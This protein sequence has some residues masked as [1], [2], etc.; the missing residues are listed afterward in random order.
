[1][2]TEIV[3]STS[4]VFRVVETKTAQVGELMNQ[5]SEASQEQKSGIEQINQEVSSMTQITE[6]NAESSKEAKSNAD[7]LAR[8]ATTMMDIISN[9]NTLTYGQALKPKKKAKK[10]KKL[11]QIEEKPKAPEPAPEEEELSLE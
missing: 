5:I 8:D 3:T 9:L 2:G 10:V 6:E 11:K 4:E 7:I 1:M